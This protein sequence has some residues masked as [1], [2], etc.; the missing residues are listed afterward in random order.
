M[1]SNE[2]ESYALP[3]VP[4]SDDEDEEEVCIARGACSAHKV[5]PPAVAPPAV[6]PP[7]VI[8]PA[9]AGSTRGEK[10]SDANASRIDE[11]TVSIYDNNYAG[12]DG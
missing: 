6:A 2:D 3:D 9:V 4:S 12:N 10:T 7:A 8:P 11:T 1:A 5:A